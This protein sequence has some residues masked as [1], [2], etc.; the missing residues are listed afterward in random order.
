MRKVLFLVAA[1]FVVSVSAFAG[2]NKK[3]A[4]DSAKYAEY[5]GKYKFEAGSP[6]D[7]AEIVWKDTT[8]TL[9][10]AMGDAT[11]TWQGVD[12]FLMS[13]MDG[14]LTFKRDGDKKVKSLHISV[15]GADLDG[16]K[17]VAAGTAF[18]KE[19]MLNEKKAVAAK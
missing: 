6:I 18:R 9:S 1:M 12:S 4:A 13:Y 19:D 5:F 7:E 3:A 15:S 10:T 11:L 17:E 2:N 8:L 16:T 14:I